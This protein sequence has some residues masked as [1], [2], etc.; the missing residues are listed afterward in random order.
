MLFVLTLVGG[1]LALTAGDL[2]ES[3]ESASSTIERNLDPARCQATIDEMTAFLDESFAAQSSE[4]AQSAESGGTA[5]TDDDTEVQAVWDEFFIDVAAYCSD[6]GAA[7]SEI[8]VFS[9]TRAEDL[10]DDPAA[11]LVALFTAAQLCTIDVVQLTSP[12]VA[13]C[14]TAA[15]DAT[16]GLNELSDDT[17]ET[18]SVP[19]G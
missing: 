15:D 7:I 2:S 9:S 3:E 19:E 18:G 16:A 4:L 10:Q 17:L 12:A 8:I 5:T 11:Q 6:T 14:Q 13:V 1:G